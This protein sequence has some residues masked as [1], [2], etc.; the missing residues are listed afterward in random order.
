MDQ[1]TKTRLGIVALAVIGVAIFGYSQYASASHISISVIDNE[2]LDTDEHGTSDYYIAL[3]FNNPSVLILNAGQTEFEI[4]SDG[5]TVGEGVLDSFTLTPL[6]STN[7]TGIYQTHSN[8]NDNQNEP[9]IRITGE[10]EY[11]MM[12]ASVSI[13]FEY[14]PTGEQ[15]SG[16]IHQ[17]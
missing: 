14:Y 4:Q 10:T 11:D 6:S 7:V 9:T 13:P 12:V 8:A 3:E 17:S 2:L 15:A 5:Q 16:F 1:T